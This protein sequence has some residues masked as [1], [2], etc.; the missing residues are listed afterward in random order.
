MRR[1]IAVILMFLAVVLLLGGP[2]FEHVDHW[3]GF[4]QSG[5]DFLLAVIAVLVCLA[6][7]ISFIRQ[8]VRL[9]TSQTNLS[10]QAVLPHRTHAQ[11]RPAYFGS[12]GLQPLSLRI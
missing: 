11:E 9:T 3:D 10:S 5:N 8:L 1:R 4:P 6:A 2:V 12:A 7:A